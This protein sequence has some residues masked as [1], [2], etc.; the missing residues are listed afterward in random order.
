MPVSEKEEEREAF[1][2]NQQESESTTHT[3]TVI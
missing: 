3:D 2:R 1:M